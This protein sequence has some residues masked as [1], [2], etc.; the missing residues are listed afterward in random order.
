MHDRWWTLLFSTTRCRCLFRND[1][2]ASLPSI[3]G[4]AVTLRLA[5]L[6]E[7]QPFIAISDKWTH[8]TPLQMQMPLMPSLD[9]IFPQPNSII[10]NALASGVVIQV[11]DLNVYAGF[12]HALCHRTYSSSVNSAWLLFFC[13]FFFRTG[14]KSVEVISALPPWPKERLSEIKGATCQNPLG[15]L[16]IHPG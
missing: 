5:Y 3:Q 13:F 9:I 2:T 16:Q 7:I 12:N 14:S 8:A 6:K 10:R 15:L 11:P 4:Q 1:C